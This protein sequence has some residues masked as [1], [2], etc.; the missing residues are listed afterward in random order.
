M[1]ILGGGSFPTNK[2]TH[3]PTADPRGVRGGKSGSFPRNQS[4]RSPNPGP[5]SRSGH[6]SGS[7]DKTP[8][9]KSARTM[10]SPSAKP[11]KGLDSKP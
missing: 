5:G 2:S 4:T 9:P 7:F 11:T 1:A 3:S 6:G 10:G 8:S